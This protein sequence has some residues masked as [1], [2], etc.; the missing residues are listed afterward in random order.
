MQVH[1]NSWNEFVMFSRSSTTTP[2]YI[3]VYYFGCAMSSAHGHLRVTV[4][5]IVTITVG[6]LCR[7]EFSR[8]SSVGASL[9]STSLATPRY[10]DASHSWESPAGPLG[11]MWTL[12][13]SPIS[14][15]SGRTSGDMQLPILSEIGS[16]L[17]LSSFCHM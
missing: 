14:S 8:S 10:P 16:S 7:Y 4:T 13:P 1:G 5:M 2:I 17:R 11:K 3:G 9:P 6:N 15:R 12:D